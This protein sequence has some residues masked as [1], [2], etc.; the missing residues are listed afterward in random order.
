M[1]QSISKEFFLHLGLIATLYTTIT[2]LI[3]FTFAVINIQFPDALNSFNISSI[4]EQMAFSLS[5]LIV[6]FPIFVVLS[7]KIYKDLDKFVE[8]RELWIRKW[9]L[10]LTLF[11]LILMFAI[12]IITLIYTFLSGE[13]STRFSLKV[14]T[15]LS[16]SGFTCW[17]YLKDYQGYFFKKDKLRKKIVNIVIVI[18]SG[19]IISGLSFAGSPGEI[20]NIKLDEQRI[21][22][23]MAMQSEIT[24]YWQNNGTL[25]GSIDDIANPLSY[26]SLPVDPETDSNYVYNVISNMKFQLCAEFATSTTSS[27]L[28]EERQ[29]DRYSYNSYI[30]KEYWEHDSGTH[31]FDREIDPNLIKMFK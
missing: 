29:I 14:L 28:I 15:I 25:P 31:C 23:L 6:T 17:Y 30:N 20:R 5:L 10:S 1:K 16:I 18:V 24:N 27:G 13:I 11:L 8:N 9:F 7:K 22:D 2:S 12:T 21:N 26:Y 19:V 4:R 3:V